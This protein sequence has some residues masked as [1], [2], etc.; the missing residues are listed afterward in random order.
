[1]ASRRID[2]VKF[3]SS[4]ASARL[5][6]VPDEGQTGYAITALQF[7]AAKLYSNPLSRDLRVREQN[8]F[9]R[10][11]LACYA[12]LVDNHGFVEATTI[13][14]DIAHTFLLNLSS[15]D[16]KLV[17]E[18][19]ES[20]SRTPMKGAA[21]TLR[22]RY[23]TEADIPTIQYIYEWLTYL[24]KFPL[25][26][27]D[28]R[29]PAE[30]A[31]I[32]RQE[33]PW[34]ITA[35][36][37]VL[38]SL[39]RVVNWLVDET[40]LR[41]IDENLT[42]V[43]NHGPGF[44]ASGAKTVPEKNLDYRPTL[45]TRQL[46]RFHVDDIFYRDHMPRMAK[47]AAVF[48]DVGS[49]R[50]ITQEPTEM[51]FAQQGLKDAL[52]RVI[53]DPESALPV[54]KFIRFRDQQPS[55]AAAIAG[56]RM[57][58]DWRKPSTID[59]RAASDRLLVELVCEVFSGNLLHLIMAGR[60]WGCRIGKKRSVEFAM[61]GGM[62]SAL[63]FPVQ[64]IVFCAL[65][66]YATLKELYKREYGCEGTIDDLFDVYIGPHGLNSRAAQVSKSIRVY[67]DDLA[68]PDF[69]ATRLI[70]LL[71]ACGLEVNTKKSF[72]GNSPVRE[73][74]GVYAVAGYVITPKRLRFPDSGQ[75]MDGAQYEAIRNLANDAFLR[76][77]VVLYRALVRFAL[78]Q[79]KFMSS[80]E[81]KRRSQRGG[82]LYPGDLFQVKEANLLFEQYD[83]QLA[84]EDVRVGFLSLR[85]SEST[86]TVRIHDTVK[87]F[88]TFF[89]ETE[90]VR[91]QDSEFYHLTVN[92][93][94][95]A[96]SEG[97][98]SERHG[99]IARG[100]RLKTRNAA[101]MLSQHERS[102]MVWGWAPR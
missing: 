78:H 17:Y 30:T 20:I 91:D 2:S 3:V 76:G 102:K 71:Q 79:P 25:N 16:G 49:L 97:K 67:G 14:K 86:H 98:S 15:R 36:Q 96:E 100:I 87:A 33:N 7:H 50:P 58:M 57:T 77:E 43:G 34:K 75:V 22:D 83:G 88:S 93:R 72:L 26:R 9:V 1:M 13:L 21:Q 81:A 89:V 46:T 56:S 92:Y 54:S 80:K 51:Q 42:F 35:S 94:S 10:Q 62:G 28:L 65:A 52:Y 37:E 74:C 70:E 59:L 24:S 29:G 8:R 27:P 99:S 5:V 95:M 39:R 12:T 41:M 84:A 61:Y 44:T 40:P 101:L 66:V 18:F 11:Q 69:A 31:W 48:K 64:S 6:N 60:T 90:T 53:D 55:R 19:D 32:D 38:V 85:G 63:T 68:V 23:L 82:R 4:W 47:W 73:S 45:Q